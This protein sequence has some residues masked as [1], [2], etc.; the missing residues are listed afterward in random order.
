MRLEYVNTITGKSG[1]ADLP[2]G[3]NLVR[4]GRHAGNHVVLDS[5]YIGS[6]ALAFDNDA[7]GRGGWRLWNRGGQPIK[8][9]PHTLRERNSYLT[10]RQARVQMECGPFVLT[11]CFSPEELT[12]GPSDP[13]RLDRAAT[14]LV[15]TVHHELVRLHPNDAADRNL[16]L[17]DDYLHELERQIA[18]LASQHAEFPTDDLERTALSDHL[19]GMAIK[20]TLLNRVVARSGAAV[21]PLDDHTTWQRM[22]ITLPE[23][24]AELERW[25]TA[26]H[27]LVNG[28]TDVTAQTHAL[29]TRFAS[30]WRGVLNGR[31]APR[32]QLCRYLALRRI[33][34]EIKN[35]WFGYGPLEDLLR[36]PGVN[37][38][39]VV[40][41]EHIFIEKAGGIENSGRHFLTD[42][43]TIIQRIMARAN[44]QVNTAQPLVDA[45]MPDGSRVN[46][47]IEP[48]A[49]RG[50]CL[51]IRRFPEQRLTVQDLVE[52]FNA[53][54]AGACAFLRAAVINRRNVIVAGGTGTGKT[55]LLNCL[56]AFIPDKERI[57]T[58]EDTAEL[59][60]AKEHVVTL[61]AR[62]NNAE[63]AGAVSIRDLVKNA[64]RMRPDR[65]VVGECRGGEAIDMLQAMNT[66]HDGSMTTVHANSP[67]G[68]VRRLEVLVQQNADALLP[69]ETIHAQ[70]ATAVDLIVQLGTVQRAG[71]KCKVVTEIT[72]VT[73]PT[74]GGIGLVP[75]FARGS[76]DVLRSTGCL[77]S[78]LTD[79][80]AAGL[81]A[82]PVA[83]VSAE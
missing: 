73:Q 6:E 76:D 3:L 26:T 21:A 74:A 70:V 23:H 19:A 7:A 67:N 77:P 58:I 69:V 63:G 65:I 47:V 29:N 28:S 50:P 55:T 48:L 2:T 30:Y 24:E 57:V 17:K 37:E 78:F 66:G 36:D 54:S 1:V 53:L 44:R 51:T 71:K 11:A 83:F 4:V 61:Q 15:R 79:L 31:T 16:W 56:S 49:L 38:I 59:Q 42:P 46:A 20:S 32:P 81:V 64:L 80:I 13:H 75:L 62:P 22:R 72:E 41:A 14:E 45:R 60:L 35:I 25:L 18:E 33:K 82:D 8:V 12:A 34:E 9:G 40:D 10:V 43:L 27:E 52:R 39:M 68:V 5:P